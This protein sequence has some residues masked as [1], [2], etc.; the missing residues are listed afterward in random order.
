MGRIQERTTSIVAIGSRRRQVV[1]LQR[2]RVATFRV[3]RTGI[4]RDAKAAK[5]AAARWEKPWFDHIL[6]PGR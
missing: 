4:Y 6:G 1:F 5:A 3:V 2:T